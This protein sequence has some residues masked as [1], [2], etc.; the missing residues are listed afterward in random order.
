MEL[1]YI[2]IS[3][4]LIGLIR[5]ISTKTN[6]I[7]K[8]IF[9]LDNFDKITS[10]N[11]VDSNNLILTTEK[12]IFA[13]VNQKGIT[14]NKK[15][16]YTDNHKHKSILTF[17]Y[18]IFMISEDK[19]VEIYSADDLELQHVFTF[20]G[21]FSTS[22]VFIIKEKNKSLEAIFVNN[23][24]L[25]IINGKEVLEEIFEEFEDFFYSD[26]LYLLR[27]TESNVLSQECVVDVKGKEI[28]TC[29]NKFTIST[30][31][32][33]FL[34]KDLLYSTDK[35]QLQIF[36][37]SGEVIY[38]EIITNEE[39]ISIHNVLISYGNEL[40]TYTL[41]NNLIVKKSVFKGHISYA[42]AKYE[43]K[44]III[45]AINNEINEISI[46][47]YSELSIKLILLPLKS[48]ALPQ[49]SNFNEKITFLH[50]QTPVIF[51][52]EK[53]IFFFRKTVRFL[54]YLQFMIS[55]TQI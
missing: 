45:A 41:S 26:K 55:N 47:D 42:V 40:F 18:F 16:F 50:N 13:K 38:S 6:N 12:G 19:T 43:N 17:K 35:S 2:F 25:L 14:S 32:V 24:S 9:S 21:D 34:S 39:F 51:N 52:Y 29:V 11:E 1:K 5:I 53:V 7:S 48:V 20:E 10:I 37:N 36:R 8:K 44:K 22:K 54:R 31:K 27:K 46:E 30:S 23:H 33:K 15:Y 3:V 49:F 28:I 4:C